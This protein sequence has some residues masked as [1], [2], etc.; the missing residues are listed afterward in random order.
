MLGARALAPMP[1][2]QYMLL[3]A[4]SFLLRT[5]AQ[6]DLHP[7]E[8]LRNRRRILAA[9]SC[10]AAR[11][12]RFG[13]SAQPHSISTQSPLTS[14]TLLPELAAWISPPLLGIRSAP[15]PSPQQPSRRQGSFS[16][17]LEHSSPPDPAPVSK[18]PPRARS[19]LSPS[20][21]GPQPLLLL[22]RWSPASPS[23]QSSGWRP[24][25]P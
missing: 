16:G 23:L 20:P 8:L 9:T 24:T 15:A 10:V 19:F 22:G 12:K 4:G 7:A 3:A 5:C 13:W 21:R 11:S 14:P 25:L 1:P 6:S 18:A 17:D 2:K